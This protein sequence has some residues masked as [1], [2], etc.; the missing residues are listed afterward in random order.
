MKDR[1]GSQPLMTRSKKLVYAALKSFRKYSLSIFTIF[2]H[3]S[4]SNWFK[5]KRFYFTYFFIRT[6]D[7]CRSDFESSSNSET[8]SE[9]VLNDCENNAEGTF[10]KVLT[11]LNDTSIVNPNVI[12]RSSIPGNLLKFWNDTRLFNIIPL[13]FQISETII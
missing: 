6:E 8:Y 2:I 9:V 3:Q 4:N 11:W 10:D 1:P 12:T 5:I 13:A 7:S